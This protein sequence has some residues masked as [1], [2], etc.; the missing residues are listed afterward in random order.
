[1]S[2]WPKSVPHARAPRTIIGRPAN[3][4]N[5]LYAATLEGKAIVTSTGFTQREFVKPAE[6]ADLVSL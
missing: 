3:A 6:A 4:P 5:G 2:A 1:V